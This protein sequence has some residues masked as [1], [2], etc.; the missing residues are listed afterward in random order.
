MYQINLQNLTIMKKIILG[1][2]LL[3][4]LALNA[5]V[6]SLTV[7][8]GY[9]FTNIEDTDVNG[10]GYRINLQYD[11]QPIGSAVSYGLHFGYVNVMGSSTNTNYTVSTL[12]IAFVPKFYFGEGDLRAFLKGVIGVQFSDIER[13]GTAATLSAKDSGIIAGAGAGAK[14]LLS[15]KTFLNLDYEFAYLANSFYKDGVM[16]SISLGVGFNF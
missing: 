2:I 8:G 3:L 6:N 11:Y 16:N 9:V 13:A 4:P 14:Y 1:F 12:P 15:E 7:G 10:S 5:Q